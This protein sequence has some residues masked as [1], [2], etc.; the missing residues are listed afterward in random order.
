MEMPVDKPLDRPLGLAEWVACSHSGRVRTE[1][2]TIR[3]LRFGEPAGDGWVS[4]GPPPLFACGSNLW[5]PPRPVK[6]AMPHQTGVAEASLNIASTSNYTEGM[7]S[8]KPLS[9]DEELLWRAVIR[10]TAALPRALDADLLRATGLALHEYAVLLRLS[11]ADNLTADG[12]AGS[13]PPPSPPA[14]SPAWWTNCA[15]A[16]WSPRPA[17]PQTPEAT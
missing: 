7:S 2:S 5:P 16:A 13:P 9:P 1:D 6:H 10:I 3:A 11:E 12:Q 15:P 17:A 14:A 8:P 4:T